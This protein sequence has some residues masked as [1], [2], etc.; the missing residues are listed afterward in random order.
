MSEQQQIVDVTC[1]MLEGDVWI[2]GSGAE[3]LGVSVPQFVSLAVRLLAECEAQGCL[4]KSADG[5]FII[6]RGTAEYNQRVFF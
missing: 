4:R 3:A 2:A 6:A 1:P 5:N